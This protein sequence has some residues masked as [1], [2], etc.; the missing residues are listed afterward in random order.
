MFKLLLGAILFSFSANAQVGI[1]IGQEDVI[2]SQI[3]NRNFIINPSAARNTRGT[4]VTSATIAR[5]VLA[6]DRVDGIAS[7]ECDTSANGGFCEFATKTI[8]VSDQTG[9]CQT[10]ALFKGDGSLYSLQVMSGSNVLT[11]LPLGN[12]AD[13]TQISTAIL[14]CGT[15]R[16]VRLT[17]TTA[18]T[19]P[20][21]NIGKITYGKTS[22]IG[23]VSQATFYGSVKLSGCGTWSTTSTSYVDVAG[24]GCIYTATGGLAAPTTANRPG[25]TAANLPPG[26]YLVIASG[27]ALRNAGG[28]GGNGTFAQLF[29]GTNQEGGNGLFAASALSQ[30]NTGSTIVGR[31][32]YTSVQALADIRIRILSINGSSA[33]IE[34]NSG[35]NLTF[36]VYRFPLTQEQ[37]FR[38]DTIG[39]KV[40]ANI[41]GANPSLGATSV[42]SYTGIEN[43]SL[44]L[45]NN[46]GSG[47]IQAQI[48]CSGTNAPTGTT[49]SVGNESVGVSFN[50]PVAG[51]VLA[52]VSTSHYMQPGGSAS[53]NGAF[54]VVET[55]NNAQTIL[56]EGK[57]RL[58]TESFPNSTISYPMRVCGTFE[59]ASAGQKTL[60]LMYEQLVSGSPVTNIIIGDASAAHG[61]NDIHWEVY[62]LNQ[63]VPAP[64]IA[65]SVVTPSSGV[66]QLLRARV[67]TTCTAS[68][69]TITNQTGSAVTSITRTSAGLYVANI[70]SGTFSTAPTC[71]CS[72]LDPGVNFRGCIAGLSSP[73][74]TSVTVETYGTSFTY[75]DSAF[76]LICM[77]AR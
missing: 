13:W 62:P 3:V 37:T 60:R 31:F 65:N 42:S 61:Q 15:P 63:I 58:R 70:A 20:A 57:S 10:T 41:S 27:V 43:G 69:C 72:A 29:D 6:A 38:A 7:F 16:S 9:S 23:S 71:T 1:S 36:D 48:P 76:N 4:S 22:N 46:T 73:S 44:T 32:N 54:Q 45:V 67:A 77:G 40:D 30:L 19:S 17:Q 8:P 34:A 75:A 11:S 51:S 50:L 21:V 5:D 33:A 64:L 59:F 24:S 25:F 14:P 68:P 2:E 28:G 18:G 12:F 55:A 35:G 74:A 26:N 52:C 49:C 39:W 53:V 56:Q 66:E 47:N